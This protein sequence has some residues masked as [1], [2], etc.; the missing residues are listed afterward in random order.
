[1]TLPIIG[2]LIGTIAQT[3]TDIIGTEKDRL[4]YQ[5]KSRELDLRS[6]QNQVDIN[7]IE[8][9]SD[10]IWKSGWRPAVGWVCV[11]GLFYEFI[12]MPILPWVLIV[13]GVNNVPPLPKIN[14]NALDTLL[15]A[16]LGLGSMRTFE[17][18]KPK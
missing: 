11:L 12:V 17:K 6:D 9:A 13:C 8:A 2:S 15:Y 7:K 5:L 1:M 10:N 18:V 14:D 4:D 16:M 3:A